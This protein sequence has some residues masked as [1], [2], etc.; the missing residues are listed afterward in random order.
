MCWSRRFILRLLSFLRTVDSAPLI[1]RNPL[2]PS[3]AME[4]VYACSD[5][6]MPRWFDKWILITKARVNFIKYLKKYCLTECYEQLPSKCFGNHP[7]IALKQYQFIFMRPSGFS[8]HDWDNQ[9]IKYY[10]CLILF[11]LK[12]LLMGFFLCFFCFRFLFSF[13]ILFWWLRFLFFLAFELSILVVIVLS[14]LA[15]Y[16]H[17][18][19]SWQF[20]IGSFCSLL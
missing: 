11:P 13:V 17:W 19:L 3:V 9:T 7:L 16:S 12:C 14:Y 10:G 1:R 20:F 2:I 8:W 15:S 5:P 6:F 4:I 18:F